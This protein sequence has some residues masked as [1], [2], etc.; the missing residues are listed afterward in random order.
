LS[1]RPT[2]TGVRVPPEHCKDIVSAREPN[3]SKKRT[4][5]PCP[6]PRSA[7]GGT[8]G[9]RRASNCLAGTRSYWPRLHF[10][11][12]TV[13]APSPRAKDAGTA[14]LLRLAAPLP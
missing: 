14:T 12:P 2:S 11:V 4:P 6:T 13:R 9:K 10:A 8:I 5:V 1:E 7:S 3:P